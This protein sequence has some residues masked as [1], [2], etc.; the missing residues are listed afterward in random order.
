MIKSELELLI[1]HPYT[2][3]DDVII[4]AQTSIR[5]NCI[6][7][8]LH[9]DPSLITNVLNYTLLRHTL[10]IGPRALTR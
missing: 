3:T 9:L 1:Y 10:V 2:Y 7:L 5:L 8:S 4:Q 6:Y